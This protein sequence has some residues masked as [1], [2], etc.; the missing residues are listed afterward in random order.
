MIGVFD[1]GIGGLTVVKA[2]RRLLGNPEIIYFGDSARV[3]YGPKS[4]DLITK[5]AI[6]S[7][8]FLSTKNVELIVVACN[9]VSAICLDKL[10]SMFSI[11][12]I[13]VIDPGV[14]RALDYT[15]G[16]IGVIGT[17][18][19]IRSGAYQR[20]IRGLSATV[21]IRVKACPLFVPLAEEG[22]TDNQAV[23]LIAEHYLA[24]LTEFGMDTLILGCTHYPLLSGIIQKVVGR[25]V[26][27]VD[28]AASVAE[29]VRSL[30]NG[31]RKQGDVR[32]YLS[33]IPPG[34]SR[35][36]SMFLGESINNLRKVAVE[37]YA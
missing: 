5:Y 10:K 7:T 29:E 20:A 30:M 27:L 8:V 37:D 2:I 25:D 15:H 32:I 16:R 22:F 26:K 12:I 13:G 23:Y 14:R 17:T 3:P 11:P 9:T 21:R 33:D 18:G 6:Q 1:S 24:S 4:K 28:S 36:G 34:F 19:T 35:A 31:R